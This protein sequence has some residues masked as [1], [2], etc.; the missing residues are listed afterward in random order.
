[1]RLAAPFVPTE[2][3]R[4]V[5]SGP[6][7]AADTPHVAAIYLQTIEAAFSD[8][9]TVRATIILEQN[10]QFFCTT[11]IIFAPHISFSIRQGLCVPKITLYTAT[12]HLLI[13][14][15]WNSCKISA[16][17]RPYFDLCF[18]MRYQFSFRACVNP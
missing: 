15:K 6:Q 9:D 18:S 3:F 17:V 10:R 14:V 7:D 12:T 11:Y 8:W 16:C 1:M 2:L 5:S 4:P 13:K